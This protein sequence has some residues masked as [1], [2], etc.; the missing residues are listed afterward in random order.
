MDLAGDV[1]AEIDHV[2]EDGAVVLR[3]FGGAGLDG[4]VGGLG[5]GRHEA[6]RNIVLVVVSRMLGMGVG[7]VR[8]KLSGSGEWPPRGWPG[9]ARP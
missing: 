5:V 8:R 9:Q 7:V 1:G 2:V 3:V 6:N 4:W